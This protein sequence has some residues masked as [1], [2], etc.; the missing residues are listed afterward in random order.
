MAACALEWAPDSLYN[1]AISAIVTAYVDLKKDVK[2]L[3]ENAQFDVYYKV[4]VR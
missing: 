4:L 3:P 1:T 2:S